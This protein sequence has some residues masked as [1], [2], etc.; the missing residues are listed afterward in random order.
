[1]GIIPR[2]ALSCLAPA[3]ALATHFAGTAQS[4]SA[5]ATNSILAN[6][7]RTPAG[8]LENGILTLHLE[9]REGEWYPEAETGPSL[10]VYAFAE[11]GKHR[12]YPAR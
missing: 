10:K 7:N 9:W 2:I 12:K 11:E 4:S 3:L 8:T 1:M 5:I 6:E